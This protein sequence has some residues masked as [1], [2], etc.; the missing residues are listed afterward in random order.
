[1]ISYT[2]VVTE[3]GLRASISVGIRQLAKAIEQKEVSLGGVVPPVESACQQVN[4]WLKSQATT[5]DGRVISL[6][7]FRC[8]LGEELDN[9]RYLIGE[10]AYWSGNYAEAGRLFNE[11]AGRTKV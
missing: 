3:S 7:W 9:L 6:S 2:D 1:M 5:Y 8:L 4:Y 10:K 11:L